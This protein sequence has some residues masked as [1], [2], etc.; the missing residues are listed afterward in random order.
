MLPE[1]RWKA[2]ARQACAASMIAH[3]PQ[4]V[5]TNPHGSPCLTAPFVRD[6]AETRA[7]RSILQLTHAAGMFHQPQAIS[8]PNPGSVSWTSPP[9]PTW[10]MSAEPASCSETSTPFPQNKPGHAFYTPTSLD[11][12]K[13][14]TTE[15]A[16]ILRPTTLIHTSCLASS[17]LIEGAMPAGC[18]YVLL[19]GIWLVVSRPVS[20]PSAFIACYNAITTILVAPFITATGHFST[21]QGASHG[22]GPAERLKR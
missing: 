20:V 16:L 13:M 3:R 14:I 17:G 7:L 1:N 10:N 12:P 5:P 21:F 11:P 18:V 4:G 19:G 9:Q 22:H 6:S 8:I 15:P 2:C